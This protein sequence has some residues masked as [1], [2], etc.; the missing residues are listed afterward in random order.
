[1]ALP[2]LGVDGSGGIL[3]LEQ[4]AAP[5]LQ[6]A[7][8]AQNVQGQAVQGAAGAGGQQGANPLVPHGGQLMGR[9]GQQHGAAALL[10]LEPHARCG[11]VVVHDLAALHRHHGLLA[12]VVGHGAAGAQVKR[13]DLCQFLLI[14]GEAVAVAG[15]HRLLGQVVGGGAEA[16]A[17]H[18][19]VTALLCRIHQLGHAGGVVSDDVLVQHV[20]AQRRQLL[21]EEL[22]V[23]VQNVT[24]Q[25]LGAHGDDL[26]GHGN[27][28]CRAGHRAPPIS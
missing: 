13:L 9:A 4:R 18:Q 21:T 16:A 26:S 24:Q 11:A 5:G 28:P 19:Q 22:G 15:G 20:D 2:H 7:L 17:E 27:P 6:V 25:Q 8:A 1:M 10:V 23:G 12:V 14:K 3:V